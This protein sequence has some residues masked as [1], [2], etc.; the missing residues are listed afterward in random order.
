MPHVVIDYSENMASAVQEFKIPEIL[1][2]IMISCG[3]FSPE[4]IKTRAY[5]ANHFFVGTKGQGGK[6]LHVSVAILLGRTTEQKQLLS[7]SLSDALT[8]K[9]PGID[10][11]T[12]EIREMDRE[13]YQK[14]STA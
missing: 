13:T 12:V 2:E 5:A 7:H 14:T 6:F 4:A 10:S 9:L 11:I 8:E 1:H 3:L